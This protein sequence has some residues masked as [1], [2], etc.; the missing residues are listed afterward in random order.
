MLITSR[1]VTTVREAGLYCVYTGDGVVGE[2]VRGGEQGAQLY[3]FSRLRQSFDGG[4]RVRSR[5]VSVGA[6][7]R[8]G[9]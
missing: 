3:F 7:A 4:M 6:Q 9:K 1:M 8:R 5:E 2:E